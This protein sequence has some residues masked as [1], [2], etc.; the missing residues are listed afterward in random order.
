MP[1]INGR[2]CVV[3][4]TPVDKVYSNGRQVYGR[5]LVMGTSYQLK[6][7]VIKAN[8]WFPDGILEVPVI[9][10]NF[11]TYRSF[12]ANN[13]IDLVVGIDF[14]NSN[15]AWISTTVG[16]IVKAGTSGY[17]T[18]VFMVPNGA[19]FII[20]SYAHVSQVVYGEDHSISWSQEKLELGTIATPWTPAPED[21]GVV[22]I[23]PKEVK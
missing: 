12:I 9:A 19:S 15:H 13:Q 2:A 14:Y 23:D 17:S 5:N 22:A 1:T 10:G 18:V 16:N 3:N 20:P 11:Y 8:M 7:G 4:G 6:T 21:I